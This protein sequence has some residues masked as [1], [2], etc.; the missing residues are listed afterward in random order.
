MG[1]KFLTTDPQ[2]MK[3]F[4]SPSVFTFL[5]ALTFATSA[6][7]TTYYIAANG[8]DSNNGTTQATPWLH[9]P[10]MNGCSGSC[11]STNPQAGDQFIFRGGDTWHRSSGSPGLGGAW[12]WSWSGSSASNPIYIGVNENWYTGSSWSRPIFTMDNPKSTTFPSSCAYDDTNLNLMVI[13]ASYVTLDNFDFEGDCIAGAPSTGKLI[14]SSGHGRVISNMYFHGWTLSTTASDDSY[15]Q[16]SDSD[17]TGSDEFTGDV[18][19][20][21]DSSGGAVCTNTTCV[22]SVWNG[23]G[24]PNPIP[25]TGWAI[26]GTCYNVNKSVF[27]HM[28][29]PLQC[30]MTIVHDNLLEYIFEPGYG[31]HGNVIESFGGTSG[32]SAMYFYNNIIRNVNVGINTQAQGNTQYYFNNVFENDQHYPPD[33]NCI[34]TVPNGSS[35]VAVLTNVYFYNN[36]FDGTCAISAYG[37]NGN[38]PRWASGST[39]TFQNN[40]VLDR[41]T[42][43][44]LFSCQSGSSC[45]VTDNGGEVFQATTAANA[46]GYTLANNFQPTS[47][48]GATVGQGN[49][50]QASCATFS[51]DGALCSGTSDGASEG[52]GDIAVY[53][54]IPIVQRASSWDAG[55]YE[56]GSTAAKPNPP[57]ALA[58]VVQ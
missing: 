42:I 3:R 44:G 43:S 5:L 6:S 50:V 49:D 53:P 56:F 52:V 40:H 57:T 41:S 28:T 17:P 33:P 10:G 29:N 11:A 38:T 16:V 26:S 2:N 39:V 46:Q 27:R 20:G 45:K 37:G 30:N 55:A 21:S 1:L 48:G 18:F 23:N 13:S 12:N 14:L 24:T 34:L 47:T 51:T 31:R 35:D 22:A 25:G 19:D 58:A 32:G 15:K 4:F 36:T 54:A 8:S 7:A 9:A